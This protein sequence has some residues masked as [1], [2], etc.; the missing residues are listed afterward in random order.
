MENSNLSSVSLMTIRNKC[1]DRVIDLLKGSDGRLHP[2]FGISGVQDLKVQLVDCAVSLAEFITS[3]KTAV[4]IVGKTPLLLSTS[5]ALTDRKMSI[6]VVEFN[7]LMRKKGFM[8][9]SGN[10]VG[11]GL[12]FGENRFV[13]NS[14]NGKIRP[15]YR[16]DKFNGL[17]ETL[18]L[19]SISTN[20]R[21]GKCY[22]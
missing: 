8:D 6:S 1:L 5:R 20:K 7:V 10:L 9:D 21:K 2:D 19:I 11:P 15:Y 18:G 16:D 3:G 4:S 22:G 13:P 14:F 12:Q 17:L